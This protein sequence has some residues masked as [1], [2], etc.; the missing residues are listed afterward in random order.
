[1]CVGWEAYTDFY[2]K[3]VSIGVAWFKIG[4]RKLRIINYELACKRMRNS[5]T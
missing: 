4:I 3:G 2:T 5:C 1:M